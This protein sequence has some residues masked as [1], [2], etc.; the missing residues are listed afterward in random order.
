MHDEDFVLQP[1]ATTGSVNMWRWKLSE[2]MSEWISPLWVL[3]KLAAYFSYPSCQQ[4]ECGTYT[5]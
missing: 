3:E 5:D 2:N 4:L 1:K